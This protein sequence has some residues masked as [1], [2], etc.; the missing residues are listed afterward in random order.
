MTWRCCFAQESQSPEDLGAFF[1]CSQGVDYADDDTVMLSP[2]GEARNPASKQRQRRILEMRMLLLM[3]GMALV[4]GVSAQ[5]TAS[6]NCP[7]PWMFGW[8][9][10]ACKSPCPDDYHCK[11]M[12]PCPPRVP[13]A[14]PDDYCAKKM[15][16]EP[17]RTSCGPD[18]YCPKTIP[19][20]VPRCSLPPGYTCGPCQ[21]PADRGPSTVES[22]APR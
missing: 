18:D 5:A 4:L 14:G 8:W 22:G 9:T 2:A 19:V 6:E 10:P 3:A 13:C 16:T 17:C 12:P 11:A 21:F 1:V 15:P 20:I 7:W